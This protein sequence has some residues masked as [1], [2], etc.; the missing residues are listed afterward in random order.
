MKW[1]MIIH[2]CMIFSS[3]LFWLTYKHIIINTQWYIQSFTKKY[4]DYTYVSRSLN[5]NNIFFK[6]TRCVYLDDGTIKHQKNI[7]VYEETQ[8]KELNARWNTCEMK[9]HLLWTILIG[10]QRTYLLF[11][12]TFTPCGIKSV[13]E[14]K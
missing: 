5:N 2:M 13:K 9:K 4:H 7:F 6:K 12:N 8:Q 1:F 11:F 10:L 14:T 3:T